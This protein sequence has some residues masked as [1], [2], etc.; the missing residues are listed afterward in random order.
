[1]LTALVD[2]PAIAA[3]P[4][5]DPLLQK[6]WSS[7]PLSLSED[8]LRKAGSLD[9]PK[10]APFDYLLNRVEIRYDADGRAK[11]SRHMVIRYRTRDAVEALGT[12]DVPY[13]PWFEDRPVIKGRVVPARGAGVAIDPRTIA[14]AAAK[15]PELIVS[16]R[17]N[18]VVPLPHLAVGATVE[19]LIESSDHK[20]PYGSPV[21]NGF[22]GREPMARATIVQIVAPSALEPRMKALQTEAIITEPKPSQAADKGLVIRRAEMIG[23]SLRPPDRKPRGVMW[24]IGPAANG[25]DLLAQRYREALTPVLETATGWPAVTGSRRE[26]VAQIVS[27]VARDLRYT[28]LH[29]GDAAIIPF[30]PSET[31][32]R[33]YGDCKDLATLVVRALH[34][35]G[36]KANVALLRAG[37][38]LS[39]DPALAGLD[40]FDHAIVYVPA[41]GGEPALWVDATAPEYGVGPMP[42]GDLERMALVIDASTKTLTPTPMRASPE[43]VDTFHIDVEYRPEPLGPGRATLSY[44]FGGEERFT[45]RRQY[46]GQDP[47]AL[48]TM[49]REVANNYDGQLTATRVGG[50]D[51]ALAPVTLAFEIGDVRSLDSDGRTHKLRLGMEAV[52]G[53][54]DEDI[55]EGD[56]RFPY[57]FDRSIDYVMRYRVVPPKG[58]R[59]AEVPK[60]VDIALGPIRWKVNFSQTADGVFEA[61]GRYEVPSLDLSAKELGEFQ[62]AWQKNEDGLVYDIELVPEQAKLGALERATW[63]RRELSARPKDAELRARWAL[64]LDKWGLSD[65]ARREVEQAAKDAAN[66]PA[67][68]FVYTARARLWERDT[69]GRVYGKGWDRKKAIAAWRAVLALDTSSVWARFELADILVRDDKNGTLK[70]KRDKDASEGLALYE[71][72]AKAGS[73]AAVER[74]LNAFDA[75]GAFPDIIKFA[76]SWKGQRLDQID[77][78]WA[79]AVALVEGPSA[80]A[81][82]IETWS[83]PR[84]IQAGL[85][86]A[87]MAYMMGRRFADASALFDALSSLLGGAANPISEWSDKIKKL[88]PMDDIST[89]EKA[90]QS[91]YSLLATNPDDLGKRLEVLFGRKLE[92]RE[93][94]QMKDFL[95]RGGLFNLSGQGT[96]A[97]WAIY[98]MIF[99]LAKLDRK[100]DD[101]TGWEITLSMPA[102]GGGKAREY[103]KAY[104]VPNGKNVRLVGFA[105]GS[106]LSLEALRRLGKGDVE[107]ARQWVKWAWGGA[108]FKLNTLEEPDDKTSAEALWRTAFLLGSVSGQQE[109][110]VVIAAVDAGGQHLVGDERTVV[111][112]G[113][114]RWLTESAE[115]DKLLALMDRQFAKTPAN[116]NERALR[117]RI[118][119]VQGRKDEALKLA[120]ER[121]ATNPTDNDLIQQMANIESIVGELVSARAR[122][123]ALRDSNRLD[124]N[125]HNELAW[126]DLCLGRVDAASLESAIRATKRSSSAS[127]H[128]R[129]MVEI[130]R[131][132]LD[133]AAESAR[134]A[135]GDDEVEPHMYLITGRMAE[136][137]GLNDMAATYYKKVSGVGEVPGPTS[138]VA[139]A[140]ARLAKLGK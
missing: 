123:A 107:G 69:F 74:L 45:A 102:M 101:K 3:T 135:V 61:V 6:L 37:D 38:Q 126:L 8:D 17:K 55:F 108:Q 2:G 140:K 94:E 57:A 58:Y 128:T 78:K 132:L 44:T 41:D 87:S 80:V 9:A 105:G 130:E 112:E 85:A 35:S 22:H 43:N 65:E 20:S 18:L 49:Q 60:D 131:G 81:A 28:G 84:R 129:A 13:S 127:L 79:K 90:L 27:R 125:G 15:N 99:G 122:L 29:L 70:L 40:L 134:K 106:G 25:W 119:A 1:M 24:A 67:A 59:I 96:D 118:L 32:Q 73:E 121:L 52:M 71:A 120:S 10:E 117:A 4:K 103:G 68:R 11:T 113:M 139:V 51:D 34:E 7:P 66:T 63:F 33:G 12:F 47:D 48:E 114:A 30:A 86:S 95:E 136:A 111:F 21:R 62:D 46:G 110:D 93:A 64:E 137:L 36:V 98:D 54:L 77:V 31:L 88:A 97:R 116:P 124:D 115:R 5:P 75:L 76:E 16:D 42:S 53:R 56:R 109:L 39:I 100:G 83:E 82:L 133:A 72:A 92:A 19:L 104:F 91:F 50:I 138:S 26:R 23:T 89:P 14:E